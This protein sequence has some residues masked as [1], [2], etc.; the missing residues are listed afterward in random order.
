[1]FVDCTL[2]PAARNPSSNG[3]RQSGFR[4]CVLSIDDRPNVELA[5]LRCS[6][7]SLLALRTALSVRPFRRGRGDEFLEARIAPKRIEHGIELEQRKSKRRV[8]GQHANVRYRE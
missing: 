6:A 4:A 5:R 7:T 1:M 8:F 3:P 2:R